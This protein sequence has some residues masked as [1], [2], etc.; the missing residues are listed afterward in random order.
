MT[1]IRSERGA[2]AVEFALLLPILMMLLLG[3]VEFGLAYN[4]Q[5]TITNAAREGA[6]TMAIQNSTAAADSAV[7]AAAP[8]VNPAITNSEIAISPS[9]CAAGQTVTVT[10]QYPYKFLTGFFGTGY[11]MIGTAAM[12]CGG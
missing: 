8:L 12:Q 10:I 7:K 11:T 4:A 1:D 9:I 5:I 2:V 3:I 6:R